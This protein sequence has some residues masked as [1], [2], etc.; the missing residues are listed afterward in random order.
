MASVLSR[1]AQL[2]RC[3]NAAIKVNEVNLNTNRCNRSDQSQPINDG[4]V[5]GQVIPK[6]F[7]DIPGPN[8][9]FGIGTF[10]Q[11]FPVIGK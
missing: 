1:H 8:G 3:A 9:V 7:T 4:S 11:Y 6:N 10:Y 2:R 5:E